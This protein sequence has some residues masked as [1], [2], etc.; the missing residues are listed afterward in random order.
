MTCNGIRDPDVFKEGLKT[1]HGFAINELTIMKTILSNLPDGP[2]VEDDGITPAVYIEKISIIDSDIKSI[3]IDTS[4]FDGLGYSMESISVG[5]TKN[6]DNWDWSQFSSSLL[7]FVKATV[8][9]PIDETETTMTDDIDIDIDIDTEP[10][11]EGNWTATSEIIETTSEEPTS[12]LE[13]AIAS[14][15]LYLMTTLVSVSF[16]ILSLFN[17]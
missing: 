12:E 10:D 15:G 14:I 4:F 8:E 9:P 7:R 1:L 11:Y 13:I 5:N 3:G 16:S 6:I 2:F 17:K